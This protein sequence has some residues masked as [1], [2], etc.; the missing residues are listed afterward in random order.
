MILDDFALLKLVCSG[1]SLFPPGDKCL[2]PMGENVQRYSRSFPPEKYSDPG[3]KV[4]P[5]AAL[6]LN[7]FPDMDVAITVA[8]PQQR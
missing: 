3:G 4:T 1:N 5:N 8:I 2:S 7:L 6:P